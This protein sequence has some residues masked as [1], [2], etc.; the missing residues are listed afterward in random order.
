MTDDT[1]PPP[2][3]DPAFDALPE[4][5][6]QRLGPA[7]GALLQAAAATGEIRA[8]VGASD[9]LHAIAQLCQPVPGEGPDYSRR[10]VA[11]LIDGLRHGA[12]RS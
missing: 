7:L 3:G 12:P 6:G 9:L 11:V 8:D 10:M 4:Y 1:P 2:A 5:F